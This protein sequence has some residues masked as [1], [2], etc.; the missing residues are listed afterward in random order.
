MGL[1]LILMMFTSITILGLIE[2]KRSRK[3]F[4]EAVRKLSELKDLTLTKAENK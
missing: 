3:R 4:Q 2:K 1:V